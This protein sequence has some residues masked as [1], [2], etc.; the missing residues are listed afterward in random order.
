MHHAAAVTDELP[1]YDL[2]GADKIEAMVAAFYRRVPGDDLLGPMYPADDWAGA[3]VWRW[4]A[5]R[6]Q[7]EQKARA[8]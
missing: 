1:I 2:L 8:A 7:Q 6:A 5:P 4:L 3:D